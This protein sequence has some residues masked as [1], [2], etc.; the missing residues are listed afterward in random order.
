[1]YLFKNYLQGNLSPYVH[2]GG[3]VRNN[4][5]LPDRVSPEY[6][7]TMDFGSAPEDVYIVELERNVPQ[8]IRMF[9]WLEG[10]D[11]DWD[12]TAA[13]DSFALRIEFAGG[14]N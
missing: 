6:L 11:P 3:F 7:S 8:R 12:P 13:G 14:T 2:Q 5:L 9:V 1:M 4:Y 10:Q